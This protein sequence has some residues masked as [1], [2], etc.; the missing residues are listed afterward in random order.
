MGATSD[1]IAPSTRVPRIALRLDIG[2]E[3]ANRRADFG[4]IGRRIGGTPT[5]F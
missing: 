4:A 3:L 5:C 2:N 1:R